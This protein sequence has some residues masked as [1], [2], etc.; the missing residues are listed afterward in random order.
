MPGIIPNEGELV[1]LAELM[2]VVTREDWYL[3]LF[4]T[5]ITPSETT[6]AANMTAVEAT[7]TGYS[8]KTLTRTTG[9]STWS[10]PASAAPVNS[11]SAEALVATTTYNSG[12]PQTWTAGAS[13]TIYGYFYLGVTSG[14]LIMA[15]LF[16]TPQPV[17][18][19]NVINFT[20]QF[21]L[22]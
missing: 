19:T 2:G 14:K 15:E 21:A 20:P 9:G 8:R 4:T 3:C 17:V 16:A 5:T 10:T 22:A 11:W 1:L 18:S 6:V 12:T 7:F 13:A